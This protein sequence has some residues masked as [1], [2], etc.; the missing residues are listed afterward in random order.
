MRF[1][2]SRVGRWRTSSWCTSNNLPWPWTPWDL[3]IPCPARFRIQARSLKFSTI[4]HIAKVCVLPC[5]LRP[6]VYSWRGELEGR[7]R[8]LTFTHTLLLIEGL[9]HYVPQFYAVS[10][11]SI[12]HINVYEYIRIIIIQGDSLRSGPKLLIINHGIIYG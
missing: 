1:R 3:P 11:M 5:T 9:S 10:K 12:L 7:N 6:L 8:R 4:F 2:L